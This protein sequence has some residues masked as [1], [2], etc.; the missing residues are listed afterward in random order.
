MLSVFRFLRERITHSAALLCHTS[1]PDCPSSARGLTERSVSTDK[2]LPNIDAEAPDGDRLQTASPED[3]TAI[4]RQFYA[5]LVRYARGITGNESL[6][7]DVVQDVFAKLWADRKQTTIT[8]S[9]SALLYTMVRNRALNMN[10]RTKKI[11]TGVA[12]TDVEARRDRAPALDDVLAA[13][14][15]QE[16][17]YDWIQDLAPRRKEAFMLSRYHGLMHSEIATIMGISKRT[18]N[19]HILL[20]LK[21]LRRRLDDLQ[22]E[23]PSP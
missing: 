15:L 6:A 18:V 20:A 1:A 23:D 13:E 8:M 14:R 16:R 3:F 21:E 17:L 4:F 2:S 11:A 7:E 5:P 19:T 12:P 10:R 9:L 22:K